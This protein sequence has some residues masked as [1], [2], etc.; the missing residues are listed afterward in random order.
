MAGSMGL[1]ERVA[2]LVLC[3][4][5]RI[6]HLAPL[7]A[8]LRGSG[9]YDVD[10]TIDADR[11]LDLQNV[12][13]VYA[14]RHREQL[15][16]TQ[17]GAVER[18]VQAGGRVVVAGQTLTVWSSSPRI[19]GLAGWT[20][21]GRTVHTELDVNPADDAHRGF[22][23]HDEVNL[24]PEAPAAAVPLLRTTWRHT[25]QV[26]AYRRSVGSGSFTYVGLGHDPRTYAHDPFRS[27]LLRAIG[28]SVVDAA[29]TPAIG[30]GLIGFG[31]LGPAH[32]AALHE[33]PGLW[34]AAVCDRDEARLRL[35]APLGV[36][37][38]T[39]TADLFRRDD[40]HLV[41]VATPPATHAGVVLD[42]L[43][44]GKHV[45]CEK[46]FALHA[47]DCDAMV[48]SAASRRLA[49]TVFQN[50]RW[51]PD[52]VALH[53]VVG[54]GAIGEPFLLESFVGGFQ[55]PCHYWH[56]HQPI[57]G[58]A[59]YDWGSHYIDWILQ[60]FDS[61]V[62]SV[63][64]LEHKR[65]WHDVTNADHVTVDITFANGSVASFAQSAVAA[66]LKPKWY[67]LGTR[68]SIVGDWRRVTERPRGP[69]GEIDEIAVAPTDLPARLRVLRPD[70]EGGTHEERVALPRRDRGAFYRNL[71]GHL[72]HGEPLAVP[73][74]QA[75]RVVAVM[76]TA[77]TS[78]EQDGALIERRI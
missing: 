72:L 30:V 74:Q 3:D 15:T 8:D 11:L 31:A 52:F 56:S 71:A 70:G 38:V 32:A 77:M 35:A 24:L 66:A 17:A 53:R 7:T 10:L 54:S 9:R 14:H 43:D 78:A 45:V 47:R 55:H 25:Q 61:E 68:G 50:R 69:D 1:G 62:V 48:E 2:V 73:P 58:G 46:P 59:V 27:A 6:D 29:N 34:L 39:S 40:V 23:V 63:R 28:S 64:G 12:R 65:V 20:P 51:D 67:V 36:P 13:V 41:I 19:A 4:P 18:F 42:A 49:L 60:L 21:N 37:S 5:E 75:R 33:T 22:R 16:E 26:L 57:S 76:E 44:A